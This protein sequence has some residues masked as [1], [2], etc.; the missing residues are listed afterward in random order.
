MVGRS[1]VSAVWAC[2]V[3]LVVVAPASGDETTLVTETS[4]RP[5][6]DAGEISAFLTADTSV[7]VLERG[8]GWVR[9]RL[10]G[11]V[12]AETL[13][14]IELA[15]GPKPAPEPSPP[16]PSATFAT[17]SP[18]PPAETAPVGTAPVQPPP[19]AAVP[20]PLPDGVAI[21]GL[22]K[23]KLRRWKKTS[24]AGVTVMLVPAAVDLEGAGALP[25]EEAER[26]AE[27][28]AEAARLKKE[29]GKALRKSNFTEGTHL[30]DDLMEERDGVLSERRDL[31]AAEHGRREQAARAAAVATTVTD[32]RGWFTLAPVLP[33]SYTLYVRMVSEKIDLE[34]VEAL[35][36]GDAPVRIDLDESK[37]RGLPPE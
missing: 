31:L 14:E 29:A 34:W 24:T 36:V 2:L 3:L 5:A 37:V 10:E 12:R 18:P 7:E 26:L 17:P 6:P 19:P 27:L 4:L 35:T 20:S 28:D 11:W 23:V 22:V 16:P 30:H 13:A 33:G 21:E 25:P 8:D 32:S 1:R 15:P 9:V